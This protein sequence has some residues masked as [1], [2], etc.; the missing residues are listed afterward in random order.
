MPYGNTRWLTET[1]SA[2]T[3]EGKAKQSVAALVGMLLVAAFG[4]G[5]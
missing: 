3:L 2:S 5:T 1:L 4:G